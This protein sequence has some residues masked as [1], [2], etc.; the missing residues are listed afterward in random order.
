MNIEPQS[1]THS[2]ADREIIITRTFAA[3]RELVWE[4]MTKPQHVANW[5]GPRG[6]STTIECMDFRVGGIWKL[7][8][9]GPDG[10]NYPNEH[11]FQEIVKPERIVLA[12]SGRRE[13]GPGV[14]SVKTWTFETAEEGKT[15]V[16]IHMVFP[17]AGERDYVVNEFGAIEGGKQTL[18]RYE[19]QLAKMAGT[20]FNISREFNV[21]RELVWKAWTER[22]HLMQWF[23]PRGCTMKT[24]N[25]DF[26]P[27]G[28]FHYSMA[29]PD[30]K[31]MWGKF[32]YR[33]IVPPRKIVLVNSFSD[34]AGGMTR[35]PFS[36]TWPL[37]MLTTTTLVER[38]GKTTLTIEWVPLYPTETERATFNSMRDSMQQGWTGTFEQLEE[39]LTKA[40]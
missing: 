5:W 16:T 15:K 11:V 28:S 7:V 30:G 29:F 3:P 9:H 34:A 40:A 39:Y 13:G 20:P 37:E 35:H 8:M 21:P 38:A 27:G 17:S 18:E 36:A 32:V 4:A 14:T 26:R 2:T 12:H 6:F 1:Q 31:Q 19:E 22:E 24:A 33:E 25:L 23:G 10:A